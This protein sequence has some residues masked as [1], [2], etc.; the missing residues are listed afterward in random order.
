MGF[1]ATAALAGICLLWAAD[2]LNLK[3]PGT[4]LA[5]GLLAVWMLVAESF[6]EALLAYGHGRQIENP[7]AFGYMLRAFFESLRRHIAFE[8][9]HMLPRV[10]GNQ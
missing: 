1:V 9:D 4:V 10:L 3:K 8:R 2:E 6:S 7:E 5:F